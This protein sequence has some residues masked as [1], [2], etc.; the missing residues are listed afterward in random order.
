MPYWWLVETDFFKATKNEYHGLAIWAGNL[1]E[2]AW[3]EKGQK[4]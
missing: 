4:R 1:A 2:T 3:W